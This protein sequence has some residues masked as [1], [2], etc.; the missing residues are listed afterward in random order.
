MKTAVIT[1]ASSGIGLV[2]AQDLAKAGWRVIAH[3]RDPGRAAAAEQSIRAAACGGGVDMMLADLSIMAEVAR[4]ANDVRAK[5]DKIDVL[6]NNAGFTPAVRVETVDG[7][8]QCFAAN[9][10]APFLLTN[11]LLPLVKAA[12]RGAQ[13]I[14][15][16]SSAHSFIKDMKWD[17]LQQKASFSVNDAYT[18]SKLA[19]ILH[20]RELARRVAPDGIRANAVHPG[21]VQ[22][23]FDS[24]GGLI[25][26]LMYIVG[27]P[28]SLTPKQ[29]ADTIVWLAKGGA[30]DVSGEYFVKR[31]IVKTTPAAQNE[32]SA[33]RLWRIS[34]DILEQLGSFSG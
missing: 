13:I 27:K 23:N 21:F 3:G 22:S 25:V 8:E 15:T 29:G 5:T 34:E 7:L 31:R 17:D 26:K 30:P 9:H 16:A 12:G 32:E 6:I 1:G 33:A 20:A 28:W 18:Q 4:F 19:N 2:V 10:M 11:L 14:N 24:H